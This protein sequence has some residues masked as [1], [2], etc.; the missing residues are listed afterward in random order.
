MIDKGDFPVRVIPEETLIRL[1]GNC[2]ELSQEALSLIASSK[3]TV[4]LPKE[5]HD[6]YAAL[7]RELHNQKRHDT[8]LA[9]ES[10]EWIWEIKPNINSIQ[11]YG[12]LGWLN[13]NLI[14]LL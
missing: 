4:P 1:L 12:R 14:D 7:I 13:Y 8:I 10:W 11:L 3:A 6:Q 5:L 9:D 2:L